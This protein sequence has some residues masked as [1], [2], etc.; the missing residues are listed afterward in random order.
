MFDTRTDTIVETVALEGAPLKM[1][2]TPQG[3][4]LYITYNDVG[5][6]AVVDTASGQVIR[7]IGLGGELLG[8]AVAPD[9]RQVYVTDLTGGPSG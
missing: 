3:T 5:Q 6:V 7:T 2:L 8:V 4:R 9:G 1:A